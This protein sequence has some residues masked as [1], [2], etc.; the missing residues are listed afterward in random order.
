MATAAT[1]K[2]SSWSPTS[3]HPTFVKMPHPASA[4][5]CHVTA[6]PA[7]HVLEVGTRKSHD[8]RRHWKG[9]DGYKL[10]SGCT[11]K[12]NFLHSRTLQT[13][14]V[15]CSP[16]STSHFSATTTSTSYTMNFKTPS[17][18]P[19]EREM[20]FF[21]RMT[22]ALPSKSIDYRRVLWTGLYSQLV[23]MSIPEGGVIS[24]EVGVVS[25]PT[26]HPTDIHPRLTASTKRSHLLLAQAL[27]ESVAATRRS[28]LAT[29]S[30]FR[31]ARHINSS[32]QGRCR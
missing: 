20:Q 19:P 14:N 15:S 29:W 7:A 6:S 5:C 24:E 26:M 16:Q 18:D 32:T 17:S 11:S 21:P 25:S 12:E 27:R 8:G 28:A 9:I 31:P 4:N 1:R 22:S 23:I 30:S 2:S 13:P 10:T 3:H